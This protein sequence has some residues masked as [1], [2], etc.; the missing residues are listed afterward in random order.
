MSAALE[1]SRGM[2]EG[3]AHNVRLVNNCLFIEAECHDFEDVSFRGE[4]GL[5]GGVF[6]LFVSVRIPIEKPDHEWGNE[7][8]ICSPSCRDRR[9]CTQEK[10]VKLK[11]LCHYAAVNTELGHAT[12]ID[13]FRLEIQCYLTL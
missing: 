3:V 9:E 13:T 6:G 8:V 11:A 5:I 12:Q 1:I 7:I 2:Y 4:T 10:I